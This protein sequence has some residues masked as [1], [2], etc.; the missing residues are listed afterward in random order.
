MVS[1]TVQY[2]PE[3][4]WSGAR[5]AWQVRENLWRMGRAEWV[6]P[7]GWQHMLD[8]GVTTVIDVRTPPEVRRRPLDPQAT[9]PHKIRRIHV[10]VEDVHHPT[11]WQRHNPYP[12]HPDAYP[13]TM[14]TFGPRV[15]GAI[16]H[17]LD[18]WKT[19][20]VVLHC[21]AGRDRTGLVLG[22]LLQLPNIP[23][24]SAT[25]QEQAQVY[26]S[27][28]YGINE[29]HRVHPIPHPYESYLPPE[30]FRT[31][32]QDRLNSYQRFLD[33]WPGDRVIELLNQ[34]PGPYPNDGVDT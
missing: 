3:A 17:V 32:L 15:A 7:N 12:M 22:L 1:F 11:F 16:H 33:Q 20:G 4:H 8:D 14:E 28:A 30:E 24:G 31:Q 29:H 6:D 21:T 18:A 13:D 2:L 26:A 27:G 9:R 25:W 34:Y 5:N 19:G 10:P 23:G